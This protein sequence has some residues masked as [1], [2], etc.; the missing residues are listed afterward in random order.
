MKE[1]VRSSRVRNKV[2]I[3]Q[4]CSNKH[5]HFMDRTEYCGG[6]QRGFLIIVKGRDDKGW[7]AFACELCGMLVHFHWFSSEGRRVLPYRK[8]LSALRSLGGLT[9]GTKVS[10]EAVGGKLY[11]EVLVGSGLLSAYT[12]KLRG[13]FGNSVANGLNG[14]VGSGRGMSRICS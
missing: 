3:A 13:N 5:C 9:S 11:V 1:F 14:R 6:G 10:F 2:L 4:H 8:P 12:S 7:K